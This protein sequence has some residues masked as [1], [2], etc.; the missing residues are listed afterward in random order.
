MSLKSDVERLYNDGVLIKDIKKE[1]GINDSKLYGVVNELKAENRLILRTVG[2]KK[3]NAY[4]TNPKNYHH[5]RWSGTYKITYGG[6]YFGTV[7]TKEQAERFVE[8]MKEC[9]WDYGKRWIVKEM[10]LNE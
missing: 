1:L 4:K 6:K 3:R 9:D 2:R 5:N 7:K 10:V 8:L